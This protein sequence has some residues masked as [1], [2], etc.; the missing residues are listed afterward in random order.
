MRRSKKQKLFNLGIFFL[1]FVTMSYLF[2]FPYHYKVSFS[3]KQPP[4]VV[5]D[6]LRAWPEFDQNDTVQVANQD[7][8]LYH[9]LIQ[10]ID[11]PKGALLVDWSIKRQNDSST[12]VEGRF[13]AINETLKEKIRLPF[14][15]S[16]VPQSSIALTESLALGLIEKSKNFKTHSI[17]D[18]IMSSIFCAYIPVHTKEAKKAEGMLRQISTVMNY[19][20][21]NNITLNGDPFITVS[22]WDPDA[23]DLSFDFCFPIDSL[24]ARPSD[25]EV[26]FKTLSSRRYLKAIFNGNYRISQQGWYTLL[27]YAQRNEIELGPE[28]IEIYRNDPH[29]GGDSMEWVAELLMPVKN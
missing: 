21:D 20:K 18:T 28:I 9:S 22:H 16:F 2:V 25:P 15:Q 4:G 17:S 27:D 1:A 12:R 14:G 24:A 26:R 3:T 23:Q 8:A 10:N 7:M 13:S 11:H 29:E 6:H 19:I 5:F